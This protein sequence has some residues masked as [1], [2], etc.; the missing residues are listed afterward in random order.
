VARSA[1]AHRRRR[2]FTLI[3]AIVAV[4][5]VSIAAPATLLV[6]RDALV[7]RTAPIM[8]SRARWLAAERIE[9][10][11]ADRHS[12][13]RGWAYVTQANYS[14]EAAIAGFT[15]F[16]RTT[17]IVERAANL[18]SAGTGYKVVTITVSWNDAISGARSIELSTV[19]TSLTP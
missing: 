1:R 3:E 7:R 10:V 4:L 14:S 11:I 8:A 13:T 19:L 6:I 16:S 12:T 18:T 17:S 5:V 2:G 9:D 15:G